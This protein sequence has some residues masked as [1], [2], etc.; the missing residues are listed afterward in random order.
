MENGLT[1][2]GLTDQMEQICREEHAAFLKE[3]DKQSWPVEVKM[4]PLSGSVKYFV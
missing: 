1:M 2:T 3:H 4:E